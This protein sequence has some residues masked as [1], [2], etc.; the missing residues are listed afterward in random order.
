VTVEVYTE[1]KPFELWP[2]V[3]ASIQAIMPN[4]TWNRARLHQLALPVRDIPVRELRWQLDLPWWR[5]ADRV[6]AITP[7]QV[8][9]DP[10]RFAVQWWRM[11]DADLE[12][13]INLLERDGRLVL[14]DGFH[15]LLKAD[16]LEMPTIAARVVDAAHFA[17]ILERA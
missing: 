16:M 10:E 12:F 15:R 1:A 2:L 17:Q 6:F 11:L 9:A 3:P 7:N 8:R 4:V 14:L 5:H 13:P